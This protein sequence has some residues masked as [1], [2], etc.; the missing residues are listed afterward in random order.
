[1]ELIFFRVAKSGDELDCV[2]VFLCALGGHVYVKITVVGAIV[3][4]FLCA[5]PEFSCVDLDCA[6]FDGHDSIEA[7]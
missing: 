5:C 1:M 3:C 7:C 4:A 2:D 6:W